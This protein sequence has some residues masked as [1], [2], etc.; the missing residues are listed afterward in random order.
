MFEL[1]GGNN[2][3]LALCNIRTRV[4]PWLDFEITRVLGGEEGRIFLVCGSIQRS[5]KWFNSVLNFKNFAFYFCILKLM[6]M[7]RM[8]CLDSCLKLNRGCKLLT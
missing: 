7:D 6:I 3:I 1:L 5:I 2:T 4:I 8:E